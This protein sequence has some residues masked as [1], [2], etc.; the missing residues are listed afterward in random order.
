[1]T[2]DDMINLLKRMTGQEGLGRLVDT[3]YL[4]GKQV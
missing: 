2:K 1:M 4:E 3:L